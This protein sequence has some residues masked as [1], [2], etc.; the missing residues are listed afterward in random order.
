MIYLT[1]SAIARINTFKQPLRI[2]IMGGGC[3]GFQYIFELS[4]KKPDDHVFENDASLVLI[5]PVS[6][7]LMDGSTL[8]FKED[9]TGSRFT[10]KN[11]KAQISCGCGNSF[12]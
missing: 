12:S 5:D 8:D 9:L 10:I 2:S 11:P 3:S 1:P 7:E 4:E 6:L